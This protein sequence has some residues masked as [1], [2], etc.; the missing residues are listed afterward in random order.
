[1]LLQWG[2]LSAEKMSRK[3]V[4]NEKYDKNVMNMW[5]IEVREKNVTKNVYNE[6]CDKNVMKM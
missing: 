4:H 5:N 1:M 6:K 2:G 3:N